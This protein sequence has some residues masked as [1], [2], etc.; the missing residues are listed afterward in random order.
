MDNLV[1]EES[2]NTEVSSSEF[3][4]KDWLYVNDN[5]N[6]SYSSQIVL[7]TT[8][9]AN[10][11][12]YIG[13]SESF[14]AIPLVLQVESSAI[15]SATAPDLDWFLGL[16]N[17]YWNILHSLTC[18]FNNG[19]I[20]QQVPFLNL[21]CSFKALTSWCDA[22]I[23]NWGAVCGFCPD[24]SRSWLYNAVAPSGVNA[25]SS[26]GTGICNNRVCP[27][28]D[29]TSYIDVTT[30]STIGGTATFT[31]VASPDPIVP[32]TPAGT[33]DTSGLTATSTSSVADYNINSQTCCFKSVT[34]YRC[35]SNEG[36]KK[37]IEYLNF[38]VVG[39]TGLA[40]T[41]VSQNQ[42]GLLGTKSNAFAQTFQSYVQTIT[43][44]RALVF[45]A[46]IRLKDVADFFCKCPLLKGSTMRLYLNTNQVFF[47]GALVNAVVG[48]GG[49]TASSQM[50]LTSP[51][52]ILGGGGTNP[53]MVGSNDIGQPASPLDA[54][55]T[56]LG[57]VVNFKVGLSIVKT[58]FSQLT[59]QIQAPLTSTRLYAPCYTMSPIA[60]QR[61]LSLTP[62]KKVL[63]N[64]IFQYQFSGIT[65]GSTFNLLVSNGIPNIRSILVVP[66]LAQAQNGVAGTI[67]GATTTAVGVTSSSLLS[68]FS[69]TGG[70]PDPIPLGNFN[71]QISGKNLFINNLQYN[72]ENFY[73]QL[74]SSNQ[75]NGSLTTSLGSGQISYE[76]FQSLYR[77]YYG[78]AS[79][80][81]PSED[82]VAKAVQL[83][84]TNLS[85][86]DI[87]LMCFVEF[88]REITI[89]IRTGARVM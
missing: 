30:T 40:L 72:F 34:D 59:Q 20:I 11:G 36:L 26:S 74:V 57:E 51:P 84:G 49:E 53:V 32:F 54:P 79:R 44:S 17:G 75:L 22:D 45:Q 50:V 13:W 31:G 16:K 6:S 24:S 21:F 25:L 5:N 12:G 1:F 64:D 15:T 9:L 71:I 81:V 48:S 28:V 83:L 42:T 86:V 19:N 58:Q 33:I 38:G 52:V 35:W 4:Q 67:S 80:S 10:A 87:T 65:A 18:E 70:T 29:I 77:Y 62:T 60:E 37:R 2:I 27:Y 82:G 47:E 41:S 69:T 66:L 14:L 56:A 63:Y 61:Y 23:E 78:D 46:V 43:G 39:N 85:P 73:E 88:E 7:D 3:V 89:D 55:A 8:P 68:P 76:D